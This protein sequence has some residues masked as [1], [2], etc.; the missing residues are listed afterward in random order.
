MNKDTNID[1][2]NR[3]NI[4]NYTKKKYG[5][6]GIKTPKLKKNSTIRK[7]KKKHANVKKYNLISITD[8]NIQEFVNAYLSNNKSILP[9][10]L[11]KIPI[12]KWD[13]SKVTNM[14]YL[15]SGKTNFNEDISE[16]DV[17]NVT[18]M[19]AMF[20]DAKHFNKDISNWDV[21][22]VTDMSN[23]FTGAERFNIDISEW[24]VSNV[25]N[26]DYMFFNAYS[27]G[28]DLNLWDVSNVITMT[29]IFSATEMVPE[30]INRWEFPLIDSNDHRPNDYRGEFISDLSEHYRN[31]T[32]EEKKRLSE[33]NKRLREPIFMKKTF[34]KR[35][36]LVDLLEHSEQEYIKGNKITSNPKLNDFLGNEDW[37]KELLE[38]IH[39]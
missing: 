23:M 11:R 31:L 35:K 22:K 6:Y 30:Y 2:K 36:G 38:Y 26:M 39:G 8:E 21:S 15:F 3:K 17:S 18:N 9:K 32:A 34:R 4:Q 24:N 37:S 19:A 14:S 10:Y 7:S 27:F 12:G 25:K 5:G 33:E 29:N 16:W 28:Q 1:K 20:E 13:V